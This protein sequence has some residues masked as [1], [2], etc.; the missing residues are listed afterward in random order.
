[1]ELCSLLPIKVE[2]C[3]ETKK[4]KRRRRKKRK[5]MEFN[6][7][8]LDIIQIQM[9]IILHAVQVNFTFIHFIF[10]SVFMLYLC[11]YRFILP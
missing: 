4:K 9:F 5:E 7:S 10:N 3:L 1:M 2:N 8:V 11:R 6:R